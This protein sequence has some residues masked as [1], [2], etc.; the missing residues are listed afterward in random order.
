MKA[1]DT[2]VIAEQEL[3]LE[4]QKIEYHT[5]NARDIVYD[6]DMEVFQVQGAN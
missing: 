1:S 2:E 3:L 4:M 6:L 5:C